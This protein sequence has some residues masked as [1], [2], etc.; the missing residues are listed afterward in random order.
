MNRI[1]IFIASPGDVDEERGI[2]TYVI[3]ELRKTIGLI[4]KIELET[5]KWETHAW[6]DVGEDAQDVINKEI[7]S[8]DVFIGIMWK[9]FGT[10]TKRAQSGTGEEFQRAYNYFLEYGKP[11]IMFYFKNTAF[12]T[13]D[14]KDWSQ[15]RK[16][17]SFRKRLEKKGVLFWEYDNQLTFERD[18]R[19]HLTMQILEITNEKVEDSKSNRKP[20]IFLSAA[21]E[22][23]ERVKKVYRLL[24]NE[25][26]EPWLDI[27]D[28]L[29]GQTWQREIYNTIKKSDFVLIFISEHSVSKVGYLQKE[30]RLVLDRVNKLPEGV[31][32][33]L[34]V[35]LDAVT[36]PIDLLPYQFVDL[37]LPEGES[38]LVFTIRSTLERYM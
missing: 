16:V 14:S 35:R 23:R 37:F 1:K 7:G 8:Y 19:Q 9:R 20:K 26:F 28:L 36:P 24:K 33:I 12:Y 5:I 38:K 13:T 21:T 10:P 22:D 18:I 34:P 30:H 17:I 25:G 3:N 6:P 31:L 27:Q 32:H 2:V 15:F 11:K 29:P 4:Q